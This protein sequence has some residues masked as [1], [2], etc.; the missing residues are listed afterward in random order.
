MFEEQF[1]KLDFSNEANR[2]KE[3]AA[4]SN[5]EDVQTATDLHREHLLSKLRA[6]ELTPVENVSA[7][8]LLTD[9][10]AIKV[11]IGQAKVQADIDLATKNLEAHR[12]LITQLASG[13][14]RSVPALKRVNDKAKAA[15]KNKGIKAAQE[16]ESKTVG[17]VQHSQRDKVRKMLERGNLAV[18]NFK[19]EAAGHFVMNSLADDGEVAKYWE[20]NRILTAPLIIAQ[21]DMVNKI[22]SVPQD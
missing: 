16:N 13:I 22:L 9:L 10:H 4:S 1:I 5:P 15:E 2:L 21:S 12:T 20:L 11:Q 18:F 17:V 8:P 3:I 6:M 14:Q 7:M 19:W